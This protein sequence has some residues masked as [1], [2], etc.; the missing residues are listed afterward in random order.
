ME[1]FAYQALKKVQSLSNYT[2]K[3][4]AAYFSS[5]NWN[6]CMHTNDITVK[7]KEILADVVLV[8]V[9]VTG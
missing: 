8:V 4:T 5:E 1:V 2:H 3:S 7:A 6:K 9:V